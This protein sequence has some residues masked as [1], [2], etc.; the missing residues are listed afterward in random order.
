MHRYPAGCMCKGRH[1]PPKEQ[2]ERGE[3]FSLQNPGKS[4]PERINQ[5]YPEKP[6]PIER[7]EENKSSPRISCLQLDSETALFQSFIL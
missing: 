4:V 1:Y 3:E 2:E 6:V 5:I 7:H